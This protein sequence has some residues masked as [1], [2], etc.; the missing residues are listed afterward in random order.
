MDSS[1]GQVPT[2]DLILKVDQGGH[3]KLSRVEL[4]TL[5]YAILSLQNS[6]SPSYDMLEWEEVGPQYMVDNE[7]TKGELSPEKDRSCYCISG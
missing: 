4:K 7:H 2:V 1:S 3:E 5:G 6:S